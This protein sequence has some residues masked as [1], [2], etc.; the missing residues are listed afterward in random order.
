MAVKSFVNADDE[1][2]GVADADDEVEDDV[3]LALALELVLELE[4]E[5]PHPATA[6]ETTTSRVHTFNRLKLIT[7]RSSQLARNFTDSKRRMPRPGLQCQTVTAPST[8][9]NRA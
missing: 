7:A 9:I 6:A 2:V 3:A 1:M 8:V 4:L 5:L